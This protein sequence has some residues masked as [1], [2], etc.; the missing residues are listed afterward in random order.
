MPTTKILLH[1]Q[2][3]RLN[4][5]SLQ[6]LYICH[7]Y[8]VRHTA[9]TLTCSCASWKKFTSGE[10]VIA[11]KLVL[12]ASFSCGESS[13]PYWSSCF[14]LV[15]PE[16]IIDSI[17]SLSQLARSSVLCGERQTDSCFSLAAT[18]CAVGGAGV[19]Q[20]EFI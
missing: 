12:I 2:A 16:P 4:D 20:L 13:C 19:R 6:K 8:L 9:L 1:L 17:S 3:S 14:S 11:W 7:S 10:P 5:T 18:H 15:W